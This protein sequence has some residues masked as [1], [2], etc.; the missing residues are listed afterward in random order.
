MATVVQKPIT[1]DEFIRLPDPPDGSK[2]ELV[3]GEVITMPPPGFQHGLRQLRVA[4]L[5]DRF[6]T[7]SRLG[8]VTVESGVITERDPDSVRGPDVAFWSANRLPF[9]L[10]PKGYP[11]VAPDLCVE[12]LSPG[13][14]WRKLREKLE[15]YFTRGVRMVWIVDPEDRTVRVYRDPNEGRILHET[16]TLSGEDVLPGFSCRVAELFV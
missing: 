10:E 9:E 2:Q 16:A 14:S 15:E 11:D 8:R 4:G 5:L 6:A 12:I 1:A 3:R 7:P 13:Q